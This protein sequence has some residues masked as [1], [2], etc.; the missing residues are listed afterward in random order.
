MST[1]TTI[2]KF[3]TDFDVEEAWLNQMSAQGKELVN[4]HGGTYTFTT[5][6][7]H[8]WQYAI[9]VLGTTSK[10]SRDYLSFLEDM[11]IEIVSTYAG[12]VY[13]RKKD[14]GTPF[15][16]HSDLKS[17]LVQAQK[18][19]FWPRI[20]ISQLFL[21]LVFCVNGILTQQVSPVAFGILIGTSI[22]FIIAAAIEFFV[23]AK[24]YRKRIRQLK[25]ELAIK[26]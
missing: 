17:R 1:S 22:V 13:L 10:E 8:T 7:P 25:Q 19:D 16:L 3:F 23:F 14:D 20:I 4:Y 11:G 5:S 21:V 9:E 18:A 6:E 15:V 12:R 2:K 26:E 24:P